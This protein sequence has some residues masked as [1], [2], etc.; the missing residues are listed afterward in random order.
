[1]PGAAAPRPLQDLAILRSHRFGPMEAALAE[2]LAAWFG[3]EG[4]LLALDE[5]RGPVESGGWAR[6]SLTPAT[7]AGLGLAPLPPDWGWR[8]GDLCYYAAAAARPG[9]ARYWLFESDVWIAPGAV[10]PL[11]DRLA[12]LPAEALAAGL[13][14]RPEA[15]KYSRLMAPLAGSDRW[16]C[17]F[18]VS[19]ASATLVAAMQQ[20]R[21]QS[22]ATIP[23]TK[24]LFPND[25]AILAGTVAAGGFS[26]ADLYAAAPEFFAPKSFATNPP[27]LRDALDRRAGARQV[28]HP[29]IFLAD[30]LSE[31]A[32][33][34]PQAGRRYDAHRLRRVLKEAAAEEA[35]TLRRA[36]AA[37]R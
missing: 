6:V 32:S 31:L 34:G 21:R 10:G 29:A 20:M 3:A 24:P 22:L 25:E 9:V 14:P 13:G 8:C 27:H 17:F 1:M 37:G 7:L 28:F 16:G 12:A 15:P 33:N 19:R 18:P 35:A 36:L 11:F 30:I 5:S 4:V 2:R 23:A 26:H